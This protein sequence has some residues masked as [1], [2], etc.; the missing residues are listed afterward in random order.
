MEST[1]L[2]GSANEFL[3]V[4]RGKMKSHRKL[5]RYHGFLIIVLKNLVIFGEHQNIILCLEKKK[6]KWK[7]SNMFLL[8]LCLKNENIFLKKKLLLLPNRS[9]KF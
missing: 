1:D 8:F 2:F 4:E 6:S 9:F 3:F 7:K 5:I